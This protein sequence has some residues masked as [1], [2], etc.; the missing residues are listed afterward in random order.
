MTVG[1]VFLYVEDHDPTAYLFE[2]A[3][4]RVKDGPRLVRVK[5]G[6]QALAFLLREGEYRDSPVPRLLILDIH[7]PGTS[8][9]DVLAAMQRDETLQSIPVVILS[10]SIS[11]ADRERGSRLGV[12][13]ILVKPGEWAGIV[14]IANELCGMAF[15]QDSAG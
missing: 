2:R 11:P 10:S 14:E 4:A 5:D 7:T 3:F 15:S 12:R 8:G 13:K 6:K 9:F 1:R